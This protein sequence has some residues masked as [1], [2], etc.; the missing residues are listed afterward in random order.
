MLLAVNLVRRG[1]MRIRT[2]RDG[3]VFDGIWFVV[4]WSLG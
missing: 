2:Y 4:A 1:V 3:I